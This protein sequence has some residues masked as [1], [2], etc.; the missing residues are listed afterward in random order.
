MRL[1]IVVGKA[2]HVVAAI[3]APLQGPIHG[4][5]RIGRTGDDGPLPLSGPTIQNGDFAQ[6][7]HPESGKREEKKRKY[8]LENDDAAGEGRHFQE[9]QHGR[10]EKRAQKDR[11]HQAEHVAGES[12]VPLG[13]VDAQQKG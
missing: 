9:K 8:S 12:K 5:Y 1:G 3:G 2:D 6:R 10:K 4:Q 7:P 13:L 11:R